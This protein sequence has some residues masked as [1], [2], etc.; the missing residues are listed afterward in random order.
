MKV[1]LVDLPAVIH[2]AA[3]FSGPITPQAKLNL[4]SQWWFL[5][6]IIGILT[7]EHLLAYSASYHPAVKRGRA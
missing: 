4:G 5:A 7:G 6:L 2:E 1:A 3:D